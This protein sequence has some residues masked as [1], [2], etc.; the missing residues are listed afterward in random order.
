MHLP[1]G[2]HMWLKSRR[3]WIIAIRIAWRHCPLTLC[4]L[5]GGLP[6]T[7]AMSATLSKAQTSAVAQGKT[8]SCTWQAERLRRSHTAPD[9]CEYSI[10][11]CTVRKTDFL[12]L[13]VV[14]SSTFFSG[15][16]G[17][18]GWGGGVKSSQSGGERLICRV[19]HGFQPGNV[20]RSRSN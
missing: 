3:E 6:W 5:P 19:C 15:E 18:G 4:C 9:T 11:L 10:R 20:S 2:R 17:G 12:K 8:A 7:P 1:P 13:L 14:K 16:R